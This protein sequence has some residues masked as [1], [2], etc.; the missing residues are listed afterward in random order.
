MAMLKKVKEIKEG[1]RKVVILQAS[2]TE[3][4]LRLK[5]KDLD[6]EVSETFNVS[7]EDKKIIN[8]LIDIVYVGEDEEGE[9]E[10]DT[11]D[12][13]NVQLK[14]EIKNYQDFRNIISVEG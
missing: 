10:V 12:F 6:T 9:A 3:K 11:E 13:V 2:T 1:K 7:L 4:Y 14:V 8:P 5:L